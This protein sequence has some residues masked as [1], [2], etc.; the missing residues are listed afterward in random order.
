MEKIQIGVIIEN[1]EECESK[2]RSCIFDI[3]GGFIGSGDECKFCIQDK[4]KQ[5]KKIHAK[6][7]YEEDS[8]TITPIENA[9]IYYNGSFSKMSNSY[10]T[11]VNKGDIFKI[12]NI[13]FRF[14][15][16]KN[17]EQN[18]QENKNQFEIE[19]YDEFDEIEI[20][21]RGQTSVNFNEKEELQN[22]IKSNDYN[23]IEEKTGDDFLKQIAQKDSNLFEYENILISLTKIFKDLKTKQKS[24]KLNTDHSHLNIKELESI[25]ENI[26]LIKSTKLLNMIALSMIIK[27]LYSPIFEEMEENMFIKYLESALQNNIKEDKI[28]FENLTIKALEKYIKE[29]KK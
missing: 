12:G 5:I 17:I 24:S 8:F 15:E 23:F 3:E 10:D 13:N 29:F 26:P 1:Y 19:K 7:S 9:E 22:T 16:A 21:P 27:E 4:L 14:V 20:K 25:I 2:I 28:L 18:F 6:I 11:M